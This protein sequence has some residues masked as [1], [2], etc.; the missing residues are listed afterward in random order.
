[1]L[2]FWIK[3]N[4]SYRKCDIQ[5][6][7]LSKKGYELILFFRLSSKTVGALCCV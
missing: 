2:T 1:M 5:Y 6:A 3:E 4:V 7:Y